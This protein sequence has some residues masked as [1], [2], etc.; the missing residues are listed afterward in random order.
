MGI[1][2]NIKRI[3]I[4]KEIKQYSLAKDAGI[5]PTHLSKI[6]NEK[7]NPTGIV[8]KKIADALGVEVNK[9]YDLEK[10]NEY[11]RFGSIIKENIPYYSRSIVPTDII[12]KPEWANK[13][14]AKMTRCIP[15]FNQIP[16]GK[17]IDA[18]KQNFPADFANEY[19]MSSARDPDAYS[20]VALGDSMS[21]ILNEGDYVTVSPNT[22]PSNGNIV[23]F[24]LKNDKAGIKRYREIG[25]KVSLE[26][27]NPKYESIEYNRNDFLF[28]HK[29]IEVIKKL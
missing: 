21:P 22:D 19:V 10:N 28:L 8:L 1:G 17:T 2:K 15:V 18:D 4:A 25:T 13:L 12:G 9:L 27:D 24:R 26:P 5:A 7:H 20:L 3:R 14:I 6:E 16:A 11:F 29:V 23:V